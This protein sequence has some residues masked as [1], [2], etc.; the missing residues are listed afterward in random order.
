MSRRTSVLARLLLVVLLVYIFLVSI[1]LMGAAFKGFGKAFAQQLIQTTSNPFV[2]LFIGIFATSL[3]QSS[4]TT[5]SIVVGMVGSGVLTVSCAVPIVM[6]ANIG[7]TVTN[8]LV[9][10]GHVSRRE[11]FRRAIAGATVHDFFNL[12]CVAIMFPL[13][14]ATGFLERLA[15]LLEGLFAN[16]GGIKFTSPIKLATAPVIHFIEHILSDTLRLADRSA[17][18]AMLII[19]IVILFFALVYLVRTMR[20]LVIERVESV[21]DD[22]LGKNALLAIVA[23]MILT[24]IIQSSSI[25]T[26]LLVPMMAAGILSLEAAFPIVIGANIGTTGTSI[27][28]SFATGNPAAITIAF[29]HFLF[30][31]IGVVVIYPIK[32]FRVIPI[33]LARALGDLAYDKRHYALLYVMGMFFIVPGILILIYNLLT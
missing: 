28:A 6:G 30:N 4:S 19:S 9:S 8:T 25:T 10:L 32:P 13:N 31:F 22:V 12:I 1:G 7:T 33:N 20:A 24:F 23:G 17:H 21:L 5:T 26:S 18:V 11:E 14:L 29:V 16:V 2:G 15:G 3:V 27:L